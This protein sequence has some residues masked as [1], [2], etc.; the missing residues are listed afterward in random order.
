M[1]GF[2]A[3]LPTI[4]VV[5]P[6]YNAAP[7]ITQTLESVAQQDYPIQI[8]YVVND[9]S[10][11][12]TQDCIENFCQSHPNMNVVLI[13]QQNLGLSAA[14]NTGIEKSTADLIALLDADDVWDSQ[15]LSSQIQL[16]TQNPLPNLGVA[17]CSYRLINQ[18]NEAL[19]LPPKHVIAPKLRGN[20][21]QNLLLG[22]FIS[23]SGSSVLIMRSIFNEIGLFDTNLRACE[24]WDMWIR[25]SK[26]YQFDFVDV[27]LLSIRVHDNNMQKDWLRMLTAELMLL[28][29]FYDRG[30]K[31][32]FLLWK[33]R[34]F[35]LNKGLDPRSITG[36]ENCNA[37]LKKQL[38]GWRMTIASGILAP[39]QTLA[40]AYFK[41][42]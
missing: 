18:K 19:N 8:I 36:F 6:A 35:I 37:K 33:I 1:P 30:D 38:E 29:K 11:D 21:Y 20:I 16:F 27:P 42:R 9:G 32:P 13:N 41:T 10:T 24:D 15:K 26:Q 2:N 5:I 25:I 34:S 22:N 4:D 7:Y 17:Y 3:T 39:L 12:N 40:K 28:N 23:G 14:R 31:N